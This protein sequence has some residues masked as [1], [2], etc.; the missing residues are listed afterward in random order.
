MDML[1]LLGVL[2]YVLKE[3]KEDREGEVEAEPQQA[4]FDQGN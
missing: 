3:K 1:I 4:G 2:Y